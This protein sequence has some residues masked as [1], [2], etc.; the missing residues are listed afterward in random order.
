MEYSELQPLANDRDA[1][2]RAG[3]RAIRNRGIAL[4]LLATVFELSSNLSDRFVTNEEVAHLF[5]FASATCT[6]GLF[7]VLV[8]YVC[9]RAHVT[10][11]IVFSSVCLLLRQLLQFDMI[12]HVFAQVSVLELLVREE[13]LTTRLLNTGVLTG[14]LFGVLF[15]ILEVYRRSVDTAQAQEHMRALVTDRTSAMNAFQ[16][17]EERFRT[18]FEN[19]GMPMAVID[20]GGR[21]RRVNS[22]ATELFG[23]TDED[24]V[25]QHFVDFTA[26]AD[27]GRSTEVF[28]AHRQRSDASYTIEKHYRRKDG[29]VFPARVTMS[30]I[31]DEASGELLYVGML[32]DLT[33]RQ[34]ADQARRDLE[35]RANYA[36]KVE[37]LGALAGG[38]AH[39]F[40]NVL[41]AIIGAAE[42]TLERTQEDATTRRH[43][44]SIIAASHRAAELCKQLLAY[45]GKTDLDLERID[46]THL[47]QSML[48]LIENVAGRETRLDLD[49]DPNTSPV[50]GDA[51]RLSQLIVS[52]VANAAEAMSPANAELSI[53]IG[54]CV[55]DGEEQGDLVLA[56]E[57]IPGPYVFLEV[58][59]NGRGMSDAT[60]AR[61]FDPFFT[62][63]SESHGLG[64]A[65]ALGIVRSHHGGVEVS[66]AEGKGT[67][68]RVMLP[69]ASVPSRITP[70][71]VEE[72][73]WV[74]EAC[75]LVVDDEEAVLE[76]AR[77][78]LQ[79][80]GYNVLTAEDGNAAIEHFKRAHDAID[81]VILD[82]MMPKLSGAQTLRALQAI[83]ARV[84]IVISSGYGREDI[85]ERLGRNNFSGYIQKPYTLSEFV[86]AVQRGLLI[87]KKRKRANAE[88]GG[89]RT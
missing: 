49:L 76:L 81:L 23:Y 1:P 67:R 86:V 21:I 24:F 7:T 27:V 80:H 6:V 55:W 68:I 38:I 43:Q 77:A 34:L 20:A 32:E 69:P 71:D 52:L 59:D 64:L 48:G 14:L 12:E 36:H 10:A 30:A 26:D 35:S 79:A 33:E 8:A 75:V 44:E 40:R 46:L 3:F 78:A 62:T 18:V 54:E 41:V 70:P 87:G 25:G 53:Q 84:P 85:T 51:S 5:S 88:N 56:D 73:E 28:D 9:R 63:K 29:S 82:F 11:L 61:M 57:L 89:V 37:S 42:F 16:A 60:M 4:L 19:A 45:A 13:H 39:E 17:S 65:A 15:I 58:R 50:A 2:S 74:G 83:D 22:A 31:T 47:L 66:S 72:P